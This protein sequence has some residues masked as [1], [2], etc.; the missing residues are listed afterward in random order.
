MT[1][2]AFL[3]AV[4][5]AVRAADAFDGASVRLIKAPFVPAPNLVLA[6]LTTADYTGYVNVSPAV[7]GVI[8]DND[9]GDAVLSLESA[10]FQPTGSATPNDIYG[11]VCYGGAG[12]FAGLIIAMGV[13]DE[14]IPMN[15]VADAIDVI[16]RIAI[17]QPAED[18][19]I[20]G[21]A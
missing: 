21:S 17:G 1:T 11:W 8:W 19:S 15:G 4:L 9:S 14:P 3:A 16:V 20:G 2:T 18:N 6:D 13:F 12:A 7:A 10:H 5:E